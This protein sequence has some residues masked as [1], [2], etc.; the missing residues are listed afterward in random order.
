MP[1]RAWAPFSKSARR[2]GPAGNDRR[3][4]RRIPLT[5]AS[6]TPFADASS[7]FRCSTHHSSANALARGVSPPRGRRQAAATAG[8]LRDGAVFVPALSGARLPNL[9]CLRSDPPSTRIPKARPVS[10]SAMPTTITRGLATI[11][12]RSRAGERLVRSPALSGDVPAA[13]CAPASNVYGR[14]QPPTQ[15]IAR[16]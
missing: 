5:G 16:A 13:G 14:E 15:L 1:R 12:R 10:R 9:S 4:G 7:E 8:V 3:L 2:P 6:A 11:R